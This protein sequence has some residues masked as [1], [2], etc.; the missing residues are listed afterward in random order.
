MKKIIKIFFITLF[1]FVIFSIA[2]CVEANSISKIS[3]DIHIDDNGDAEVTEIWNCSAN[4]GT[5]I[6]HPYYNLG[7]SVIKNLSVMDGSTPYKTLSKWNTSGSLSGKSGKCGINN[8]S[9]GVELC[10]GISKYG[11]HKYTVKY[12]ITNFVSKLSDSQMIYWTLIPYKFSNSIGSVY[13]KI[14]AN[15]S[16]PDSIDVWGYGNYGGTAYVYNGYIEMQSDGRLDTNEYMTILV[17]F[18]SG[19]FN[20][21][22]SLNNNFDYYYKIAQEGSTTYNGNNNSNNSTSIPFFK[23]IFTIFYFLIRFLP[24]ILVSIFAASKVKKSKLNLGPEGKLPKDIPYYRDIPCNKDLFRVYYIAYQYGILKNKTDILGAIILKWLK[25]SMIRIEQKEVGSIF[26]KEDT[27]IILNETNPE[28][29]TNPD[30]QK[31]FRMLYS[32]SKD[33]ILENKEFESWCKTSYSKILSW[34][35]SI[36]KTE[37]QNLVIEDLVTVEQKTNLKLFSHNVF[38]ATPA[39]REEAL[40]IA[41]LKKYLNDYTLIKDREAIE[42]HLFEEYLIYAQIMGIALKV[43]D[44]FKDLY[45]KILE[46]SKFTS[47]NNILFIHTCST[48]GIYQANTA[49]SKAQRYSSGG[50]G[51]SSG[52]G[53][54]GSFGGG[55][56]GGG[57]R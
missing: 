46:E 56:G 51:F 22:N 39:L 21:K 55:G 13:I 11:T 32:A 52:G 16:I 26:K 4:Q 8:I 36:I 37:Q 44:Q 1:T 18:P 29:L 48:R 17:K 47:Y 49:K 31:L 43:A 19:T 54:H 3:M 34:F 25:D 14:H 28:L 15:F 35:D 45:P 20:T 10:W 5:E 57:F 12:T 53:G 38:S 7:N 41:G 27:V 6:Y 24:F 30:E 23:V 42:V 50:G 40:K 2:N 33:G 9:N